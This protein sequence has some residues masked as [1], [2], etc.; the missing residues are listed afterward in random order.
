MV[1]FVWPYLWPYILFLLLVL[2][3]QQPAGQVDWTGSGEQQTDGD[4]ARKELV[5]VCYF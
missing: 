2:S 1:M 3:L 4:S 5:G